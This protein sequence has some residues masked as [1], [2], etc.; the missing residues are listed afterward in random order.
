MGISDVLK[1][2]QSCSRE[3]LYAVRRAAQKRVTDLNHAKG[4]QVQVLKY[5][6]FAMELAEAL[7]QSVHVNYPFMPEP[8]LRAWAADIDKLDRIDH[9]PREVIKAAL[10]WSQQDSFWK[11]NIRSGGTFR[12]NFQKVYGAAKGKLQQ[13]GRVYKV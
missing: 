7:W 11:M 2:V 8:N 10:L 13:G 12:K 6:D 4:A 1:F 5:S 9:V 3:E